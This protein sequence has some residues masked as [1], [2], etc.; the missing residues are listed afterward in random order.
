M[1]KDPKTTKDK[2]NAE[3]D[4]AKTSLLKTAIFVKIGIKI[5]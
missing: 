3:L 5:A 4:S 1:S 2:N